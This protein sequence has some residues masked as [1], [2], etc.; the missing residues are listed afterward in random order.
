MQGYVYTPENW[1]VTPC[2]SWGRSP[3]QLYPTDPDLRPLLNS[4]F[5]T[6][7]SPGKSNQVVLGDLGG[8]GYS[9]HRGVACSSV[10]TR[11]VPRGLMLTSQG[12]LICFSGPQ[13][14]W[15]L[16]Q[17]KRAHGLQRV[18]LQW[19]QEGASLGTRPETPRTKST[20]WAV[21]ELLGEEV[22]LLRGGPSAC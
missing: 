14:L 7:G 9:G 2:I 4:P 11:E 13:L 21:T 17:A 22:R 19:S 5:L 15:C 3:F 6:Q 18:R 20:V 8:P 12:P 10:L 16:G 1:L